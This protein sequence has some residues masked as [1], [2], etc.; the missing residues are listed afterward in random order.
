MLSVN[1]HLREIRPSQVSRPSG[2]MPLNAM[3]LWCWK[4]MERGKGVDLYVDVMYLQFFQCKCPPYF[5]VGST[6]AEP[7]NKIIFMN[8]RSLT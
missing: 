8:L 6:H 1:V 2:N 4:Q 7:E 3:S 5:V